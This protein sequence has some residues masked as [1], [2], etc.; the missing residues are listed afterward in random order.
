MMSLAT[1]SALRVIGL[2][3]AVFLLPL[4]ANAQANAA[5][6]AAA[7]PAEPASESLGRLFLTPQ[8]RQELDRRRQLNI[9]ETVANE[10]ASTANGQ[11]TSS[12]GRT[13]T[14]INETPQFE[15]RRARDPSRVAI[16]AR[17]GE[18]SL[19]LRIGETLD[20][21]K[22]EVTDGLGGGQIRIERRQKNGR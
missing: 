10:G 5:T 12:S 2:A 8:Q 9:A 19:S 13:T 3:A 7:T 1:R 20:H 6:K 17:E 11:V 22:G 15:T 4:D 14:W 21:A 16:P 18:P